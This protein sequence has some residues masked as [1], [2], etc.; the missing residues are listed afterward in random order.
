M[1]PDNFRR[2][3]D[4]FQFCEPMA[5]KLRARRQ[6]TLVEEVLPRADL[7]SSEFYNDFLSVDGLHHGI[8]IYIFDG[9]QDI[10]DLRIWRTRNKP[11]FNEREKNLLDALEPFLR[12]ALQRQSHIGQNLTAREREIT[13]LVARGCTDRDIGRILGISFSTVRTHL[14]RALE[15]KGCANR[16]ELAAFVVRGASPVASSATA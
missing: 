15:K 10:G 8:G 7:E 14:N 6:A 5:F 11:E 4:W 2:Y 3:E 1:D 12:R 9:N 13:A 16:A